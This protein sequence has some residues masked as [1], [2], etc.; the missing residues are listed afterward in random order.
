MK[1]FISWSKEKSGLYAEAIKEWLSVVIQQ[2]EIFV[3]TEDI[4]KGSNWFSIIS[5]ELEN[6]NFGIVCITAENHKEPW[7]LFESG[8]IYKKVNESKVCVILFDMKKKDL[9]GPLSHFNATEFSKGEIYK[10]LL[11]I[12]ESLNEGKLEESKLIKSFEK[13]WGDLEEKIKIINDSYKVEDD[14]EVKRT[15]ED[16]IEETLLSV[17][18]L[19]LKISNINSKVDEL[20]KYSESSSTN[21]NSPVLSTPITS[22]NRP[23]RLIDLIDSENKLIVNPNYNKQISRRLGDIKLV[24][25]FEFWLKENK[26]KKKENQGSTKTNKNSK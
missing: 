14:F 21:L 8:A 23:R 9:D 22:E 4:S 6:T 20:K 13:W 18:D 3:S 7:I 15:S 2:L 17:R 11:S 12:N 10:L 5:K 1:I 25:I 16:L 26:E 24:D 19:N